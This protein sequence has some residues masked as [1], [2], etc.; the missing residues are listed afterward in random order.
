MCAPAAVIRQARRLRLAL[1]RSRGRRQRGPPRR[2]AAAQ[3]PAGS[4][5]HTPT[6]R[7]FRRDAS[8][9]GIPTGVVSRVGANVPCHRTPGR[10]CQRQG[11]YRQ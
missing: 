7:R 8:P 9:S 2:A 6:V 3:E 11:A 1:L 4:V 10:A 5:N